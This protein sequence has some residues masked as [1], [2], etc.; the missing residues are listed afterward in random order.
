[1]KIEKQLDSVKMMRE[2]REE[3]SREIQGMNFEQ[4]REYIEKHLRSRRKA[5]KVGAPK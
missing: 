3:I 2:I 5:D 4:E 1:M